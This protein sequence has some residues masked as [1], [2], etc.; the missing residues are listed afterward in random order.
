[1]IEHAVLIVGAGPTGLMLAGELAIAGIDVA[2]VERRATQELVGSRARGLLPR[3]LEL[4]DQRGIAERFVAAGTKHPV[5]LF[6]GERLDASDLPTRFN[7]W[8]GLSQ[9]QIEKMLA[10]WVAELGVPIH[11]NSEVLDLVQREAGVDVE[12]KDG[13]RMRARYLVGCD[14]GRSVVRR[15][16]GIDFEGWDA[17]LSYL[18]FEGS[19]SEAPAWGIRHG[20]RGTNAL[21][22]LDEGRRVGGVVTEQQLHPADEPT[23]EELRAAL[24]AAY[25]TDYGVH[26]VTWL[27]RFTD[28]ARQAARYRAGRLLLAGDAAHVHSPVGGQGLGL[29]IQDAVNLGWKLAQAVKHEAEALLDSYEAEQKPVAARVLKDTLALTALSRGDARTSALR[30]MLAEMTRDDGARRWYAARMS[31]LDIRHE[32]VGEHPLVGRRMP[33]INLVTAQ[34]TQ[35]LFT[36]LHDAPA[37]LINFGDAAVGTAPPF[38]NLRVVDATCEDQWMPDGVIAPRAVLVRPD[39]HVAWTS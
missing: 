34:G 9:N 3:T 26:D 33:D 28:A 2:L 7:Y 14:G 6:A 32:G 24:V 15:K 39:G 20:E 13:R 22:P 4:F 1:M 5:V 38:D 37:L 23:L 25:G 30:E 10:E 18:I 31:G 29:G 36:L 35:R 12:L 8:L 21:G 11:R 19:M 17:T 27:S 16:A